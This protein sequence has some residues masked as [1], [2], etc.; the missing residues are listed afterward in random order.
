M[1]NF[2]LSSTGEGLARRWKG[3]FSG[4]VPVVALLAPLLGVE[5]PDLSELGD[6]VEKLI[7]SGWAAASAGIALSGWIRQIR[8]KQQKLGRYSEK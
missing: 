5:L 2:F 3:I 7:L 1:K 6:L 4:V 8:F